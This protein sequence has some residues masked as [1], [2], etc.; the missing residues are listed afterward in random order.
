MTMPEK[1]KIFFVLN[2][3]MDGE[4][5]IF[6]ENTT[7]YRL[8]DGWYFQYEYGPGDGTGPFKSRDE[9][10]HVATPPTMFGL[11]FTPVNPGCSNMIEEAA[12]CPYYAESTNSTLYW[13]PLRKSIVEVTTDGTQWRRWVL[14]NKVDW[15]K[16]A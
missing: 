10:A 2:G 9:A 3:L 14:Q 4:A 1:P 11:Q 13:S 16:V 12:D 15:Q 6:A 8:S 5:G 7:G